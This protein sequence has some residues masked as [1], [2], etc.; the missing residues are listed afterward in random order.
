MVEICLA[1]ALKKAVQLPGACNPAQDNAE[2]RTHPVSSPLLLLLLLFAA[3][4]PPLL[5]LLLLLAAPLL[6]L[7]LLLLLLFAAPLLPLLLLLLL[8]APPLPYGQKGRMAYLT[9]PCS[10]A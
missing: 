7:L 9:R 1:L 8:F 2:Q 5:L 6:P 10:T 4:L 3:P